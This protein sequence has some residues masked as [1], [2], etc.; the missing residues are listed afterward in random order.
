MAKKF[1]ITSDLHV[2]DCGIMPGGNK[3]VG[4]ILRKASDH[5]PYDYL[6][7]LGD[8]THGHR[9]NS[10]LSTPEAVQEAEEALEMLRMTFPGLP[11]HLVAGN[12]DTGWSMSSFAKRGGGCLQNRLD[13]YR[14]IYGPLYSTDELGDGLA[15]IRLW[16]EPFFYAHKTHGR[17]RINRKS[18]EEDRGAALLGDELEKQEKFL[19]QALEDIERHDK[20]F[21]LA[22]HEPS[23]MLS[24]RL[25]NILAPHRDRLLVTLSGH[26]HARWLANGINAFRPRLREIFRRYRIQ[27]VPSVWGV[28][29]PG[30]GNLGSGWAA[31]EAN[32][33][34]SAKLLIYR[35]RRKKFRAIPLW[36]AR[37]R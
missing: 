3:R 31:L 35:S 18:R 37:R 1:I 2:S 26:L 27:T 16:S 28:P 25:R 30:A 10:G 8:R 4:D 34:G 9:R 32:D 15:L 6:L 36:P 14:R 20:W 5:G 12:H 29:I 17:F 13:Q 22:I 11:L 7:D 21:I 19:R 24:K 23:A 33:D